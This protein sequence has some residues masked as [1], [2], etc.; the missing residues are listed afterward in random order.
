MF[1]YLMLGSNDLIRAAAFYD[2]V[3]AALGH[4]RCVT[5]DD[6]P[7][8]EIGWGRYADEGR[9]ELAL[10]LCK[11]F[12]GQPATAGNGTMIALA[13]RSRAQVDAFHAAAMA[14]GGRSEGAPGLRPHYGP[15]FYAAYV[16][17]PYGNK[18]AAVCRAAA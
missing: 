7:A 18:L 14:H 1:T 10:W 13:A 5:E 8:H 3:L 9:V 16:R 17:D 4:A 11:P 2:P 12:N 15:D 6:D